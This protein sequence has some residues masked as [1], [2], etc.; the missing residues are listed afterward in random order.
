MSAQLVLCESECGS[1][2]TNLLA[3]LVTVEILRLNLRGPDLD[4]KTPSLGRAASLT[5]LFE[6]PR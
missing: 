6:L 1:F 3:G 2:L 5:A 4:P